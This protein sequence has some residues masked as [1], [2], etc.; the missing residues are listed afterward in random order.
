M[1][2][3]YGAPD[4]AVPESYDHVILP[5]PPTSTSALSPHTHIEEVPNRTPSP[6]LTN[7]DFTH[8]PGVETDPF[9]KECMRVITTFL[10]PGVKELNLQ[11]VVRETA[12]RT[13]EHNRHPDGV[14]VI[15]ICDFKILILS[16]FSRYTRRFIMF[17]KLSAY[18]DSLYI[19]V[20]TSIGPSSFSGM[21]T[22]PSL[23][24]Y[25]V[26]HCLEQV[27]GRPYRLAYWFSHY[28]VDGSQNTHSSGGKSCVATIRSAIPIVWGNAN[29]FC[30][31][32][33]IIHSLF[34]CVRS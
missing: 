10:R 33:V 12:I 26:F 3:E 27:S 7:V 32:R 22:S 5:S 17:W 24:G 13:L 34:A 2:I 21:Y 30:L 20:P 18:A 4:S 14:G 31:E 6:D 28:I 25:P 23:P 15:R 8:V 29:I 16:S 19:T 1:G 9:K 11:Q